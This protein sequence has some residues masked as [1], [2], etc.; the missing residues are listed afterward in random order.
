MHHRPIASCSELLDRGVQHRV[1]QLGVR[2]RAD[3]PADNHSIETIDHGRQIHLASRD[4]ELRDAAAGVRAAADRPAERGYGDRLSARV[5]R[6]DGCGAEPRAS[7]KMT[8]GRRFS[9]GP[10]TPNRLRPASDGKLNR[11][12]R[13]IP[14]LLCRCFTVSWVQ[15]GRKK[16]V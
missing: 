3:R 1:D 15:S 14:P 7:P 9:A 12:G 10:S 8:P 13:C 16:D 11:F 5:F 4:L 6:T 2:P